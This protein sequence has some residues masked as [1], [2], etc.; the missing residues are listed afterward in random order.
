ISLERA[1]LKSQRARTREFNLLSGVVKRLGAARIL[2]CGQ[3]NIP[4]AFQSVLAWYLG[5]NTGSLYFDPK[6]ERLHPHSVVEFYP[7]SHGWQ[8]FPAHQGS[9]TELARC[10]GLTLRT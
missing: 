1:D 2:A 6:H 9:A 8:V 4:I 5:T 3:P 10:R 7:H